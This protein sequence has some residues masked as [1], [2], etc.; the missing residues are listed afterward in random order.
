MDVQNR[1]AATTLLTESQSDPNPKPRSTGLAI[2]G[3]LQIGM[4]GLCALL[5]PLM[6]FSILVGPQAGSV[7]ASQMLPAIGIYSLLAIGLVTLGIGSILARRWARA[8]TLVLAW[9]WLVMGIISMVSML[10]VMPN[11]MAAGTPAP[12]PTALSFIYG[13]MI[14]MTVG[15]YIILPGIFILFYRRSDV[16][17]TCELCDPKVR[18]T[19]KCPLPVLSLSLMLAFGTSSVLWGAPC[20]YVMPFFGIFIKGIPGAILMVCLSVL[21]G[22]LAWA[23]YKMKIS[24]WWITLAVLLLAGLSAVITFVFH[25][26]IDLYREMNFP[27]DQLDIMEKSGAFG[28][29]FPLLM[30][31]NTV[32]F[33]GYLLWVRRYFLIP[34]D[35]QMVNSQVS[36]AV[37]E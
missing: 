12:S 22:Y 27:Q 4:G 33:I 37:G 30:A 35:S 29:N 23:I 19:D 6:V 15:I 31:I 36:S 2:F 17:A 25:D 13:V 20:G 24:A 32:A 8:L 9:M 5:V 1:W 3:T 10:F 7:P 18:W 26:V 16:K 14:A 21:F 11:I 28:M 34:P